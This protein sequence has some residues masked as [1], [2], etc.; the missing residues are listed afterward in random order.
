MPEEVRLDYQRLRAVG[1]D[2]EESQERKR[3]VLAS[4]LRLRAGLDAHFSTGTPAALDPTRRVRIATWNIR[5]LATRNKYGRRLDDAYWYIAEIL[6]R[7]DLVAIQEVRGDLAAL[8]RV[9]EHLGDAWDFLAT[10]VTEGGPGNG[11]RMVFLYDTRKV[12][13]RG[14]AGELTLT[15]RKAI[16]D[17]R[18]LELSSDDPLELVFDKRRDLRLPETTRTRWRRG[19]LQSAQVAYI[20]LPEGAALTLPPGTRLRLPAGT[21]LR[22]AGKRGL[23]LAR[24]VRHT[25]TRGQRLQL[26]RPARAAGLLQFARTPYYVAFRAGGLDLVLCTV[27]IY[28][29]SASARSPGMQRRIAEIERLTEVLS[30]RARD[31]AGSAAESLFLVLGDF[32]IIGK[33]HRTMRALARRGFVI[34]EGIREIPHGTN[35]SRTKFYDQIAYYGGRGGADRARPTRAG[36]FDFFEH[37]YRDRERHPDAHDEDHLRPLM[38]RE[39]AASGSRAKEWSYARWRTYQMSDHLPMW[40]ELETDFAEEVLRGL[41]DSPAPATG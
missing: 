8:Q 14:I 35:V 40:V 36:V 38:R 1:S 24:A 19:E 10:D 30:R 23:R 25:I 28:Y 18:G 5:E 34:P 7:F 27:H 15:D 26:P 2:D 12:T 31:E 4:L 41:L 39:H 16:L 20:D 22:R 6:S 21:P 32:N 37:V 9:M 11:E 3:Q 13:F 33:T 17:S 29:G